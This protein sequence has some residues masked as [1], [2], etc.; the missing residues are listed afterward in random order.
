MRSTPVASKYPMQLFER[1]LR[2]RHRIAPG[3]SSLGSSTDSSSWTAPVGPLQLDRPSWTAPVGPRRDRTAGGGRLARGALPDV[4]TPRYE[5]P[6]EHLFGP[7]S[8]LTYCVGLKV[9]AGMVFASDSRT[10]AGFDQI[11]TFRKTVVYERPRD[12]FMVLLSSGN[13]SITQSVREM[14][15]VERLGRG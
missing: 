11:S 4:A 10:N 15:Q 3:R 13:L 14:L 12:R 7:G 5:P 6:H 1:P 2:T 8:V 9:A